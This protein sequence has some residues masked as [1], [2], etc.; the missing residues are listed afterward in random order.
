M[1]NLGG[2]FTGIS[3]LRQ[4]TLLYGCLCPLPLSSSGRAYGVDSTSAPS[5][6]ISVSP[7]VW[8]K[9]E[10]NYQHRHSDLLPSGIRPKLKIWC[11]EGMVYHTDHA[12]ARVCVGGSTLQG[13]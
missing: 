4:D 7:S 11:V 12:A 9:Q 5:L 8:L 3:S 10:Q 13:M 1:R 6:G 2:P